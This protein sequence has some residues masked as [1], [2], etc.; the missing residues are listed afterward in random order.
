MLEAAFTSSPGPVGAEGLYARLECAVTPDSDPRLL[1]DLTRAVEEFARD[2]LWVS[3]VE[4]MA[5]MMTRES[6]I[7][8]A[9]LKRA[10]LIH[11][12]R[13]FKPGILRGIAQLLPR[14][15]ELREPV[16][17]ILARSGEAGSDVL[18]ELLVSSDHSSE[19]RAYRTAIA[20]CPSAG[21]ALMHLLL[22]PRWYVVRNV[23]EL[24]GEMRVMDSDTRLTT[25]LRHSDA[26]VRR[27]SA[28]ALG[29]LGTVRAVHAL[30]HALEDSSS[31][32]RL[33]A[34]L[35][36]SA[37]RNARS[38][39]P[40]LAAL[41][42]EEDTE[43]QHAILSALGSHPTPESVDRLTQAARSGGLLNR[44]PLAYRLEAIEA[45]SVAGTYAALASLR[46]LLTD[47]DR[48]VRST[49]ERLL[50]SRA[51]TAPDLRPVGTARS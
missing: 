19:R 49:A 13:L 2:G 35:G 40:L 33:Q 32:V 22:D 24:L 27:S 23:A 42:A 34:V 36:L 20:H 25:A 46:T 28:A 5:R 39:G 9:D 14:R 43:V 50:A 15:R 6:A 1:D 37:T 10:F 41:D 38:V 21:T 30:Q 26:R 4:V 18:I 17:Q 47:R 31:S 51:H 12:R 11:F 7:T 44:K 45:L 8:D 3:V 29:R 48:D 16:Q